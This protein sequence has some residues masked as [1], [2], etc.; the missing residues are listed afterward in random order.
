MNQPA[1]KSG[2]RG[3]FEDG[4]APWESRYQGNDVEAATYQD[5]AKAALDYARQ[6]LHVG[7]DILEVGCGTG[8]L[9]HAF[10]DAGFSVTS[11]D[12]ALR[13][14]QQAQDRMDSG[15]T[16]VADIER[17]PFKDG[18]FDAIVLIGVISYVND[19][20]LA[21]DN[22]RRLLKRD[23]ILIISS[24]NRNLLL[25]SVSRR[26]ARLSGH[27][28]AKQ[29]TDKTDARGSKFLR[30]TCTYYKA[31][32]FNKFVVDKGYRRIASRNVG[33]GRLRLPGSI[34][35]PEKHQVRISR[36][37]TAISRYFPF[38]WLGDFAFANVA[39]F[40]RES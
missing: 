25:N 24:A 29:T 35:L 40:R 1:Q 36:S 26:L 28:A 18:A 5:R 33:F 34:A 4:D 32:V 10:E 3:F 14:A 39:C 21:L 2:I 8:H 12:I 30:E 13:M 11:C 23:G 9:S 7:A 6:F 15:A 37:L 31:S 16:L 22:I 38:R 19:A 20:D 17:P 27:N